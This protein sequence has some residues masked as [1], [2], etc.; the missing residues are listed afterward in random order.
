M[1]LYDA[2]SKRVISVTYSLS[3]YYSKNDAFCIFFDYSAHY[4]VPLPC[5]YNIAFIIY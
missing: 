4:V 2:F 3:K 5:M 1:T